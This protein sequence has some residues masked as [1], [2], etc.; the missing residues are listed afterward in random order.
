MSSDAF[1]STTSAA[2][3][4]RVHKVQRRGHQKTLASVRCIRRALSFR[5]VWCYVAKH[6]NV[7]NARVVGVTVVVQDIQPQRARCCGAAAAGSVAYKNLSECYR[8]N[9]RKVTSNNK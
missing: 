4:E 1:K 3:S 8:R 2:R 7:V 9:N 6:F 5:L